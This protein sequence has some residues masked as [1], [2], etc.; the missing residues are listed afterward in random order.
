MLSAFWGGAPAF[1]NRLFTFVLITIL[2]PLGGGWQAVKRQYSENRSGGL[3]V[4]PQTHVLL[5]RTGGSCEGAL[6]TWVMHTVSLLEGGWLF[7]P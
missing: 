5:R 3:N 7:S 4:L 1:G 2:L 6:C